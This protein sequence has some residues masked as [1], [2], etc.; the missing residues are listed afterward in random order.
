MEVLEKTFYVTLKWV[1]L[2]SFELFKT[3]GLF[4]LV[5]QALSSSNTLVLISE[6]SRFQLCDFKEKAKSKASTENRVKG[7]YLK[8]QGPNAQSLMPYFL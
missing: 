2:K 6:G 4:C 1:F 3:W 5:Y 8:N 7:F